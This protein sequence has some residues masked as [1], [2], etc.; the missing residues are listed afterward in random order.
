MITL[1]TFLFKLFLLFIIRAFLRVVAHFYNLMQS[2]F[3]APLIVEAHES[4]PDIFA[5]YA[6]GSVSH[7][8]RLKHA[9]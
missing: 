9:R 7:I 3:A 1:L 2:Y 5:S 6:V 4:A 8:C